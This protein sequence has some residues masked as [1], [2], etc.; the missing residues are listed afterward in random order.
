MLSIGAD[1]FGIIPTAFI[2]IGYLKGKP[3]NCAAVVSGE[4][5]ESYGNSQGND[6]T[7]IISPRRAIVDHVICRDG[8]HPSRRD[9]AGRSGCP[10][11]L[12]RTTLA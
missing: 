2:N 12:V 9:D 5:E 8:F 4:I 3:L 1:T 10:T 6:T 11:W 7:A